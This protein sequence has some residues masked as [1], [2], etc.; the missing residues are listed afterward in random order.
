MIL[1]HSI[2][3]CIFQEHDRLLRIWRSEGKELSDSTVASLAQQK[4]YLLG[5]LRDGFTTHSKLQHQ[6]SSARAEVGFST[7]A[8][9]LMS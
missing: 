9:N 6:I 1:F 5:Q 2:F 7:N 4:E 3:A 8:L